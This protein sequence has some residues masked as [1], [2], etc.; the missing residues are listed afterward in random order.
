[1]EPEPLR[2]WD[3]PVELHHPM[4]VYEFGDG[5]LLR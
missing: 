3:F 2:K 1:M 5:A 4:F